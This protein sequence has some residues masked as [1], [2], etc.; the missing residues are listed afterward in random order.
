MSYATQAPFDKINQIVT[1]TP[2]VSNN[3]LQIPFTINPYL[4]W[5][6]QLFGLT[7]NGTAGY[8]EVDFRANNLSTN[9]YVFGVERNTNGVLTTVVPA[10]A[11]NA[12]RSFALAGS[13]GANVGTSIRIRSLTAAM[14]NAQIWDIEVIGSIPQ[15]NFLRD[16]ITASINLGSP[17]TEIDIVLPTEFFGAFNH[18]YQLFNI[19]K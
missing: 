15:A 18:R 16:K 2:G 7:N 17:L 11:G 13:T 8:Q 9:I 19:G 6:L 1:A 3:N 10:A 5:E 4:G 14:S 12:I